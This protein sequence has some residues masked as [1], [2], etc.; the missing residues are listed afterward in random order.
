MTPYPAL[1][2][3]SVCFL[4]GAGLDA[5]SP[6]ER[7]NIIVVFA[8]DHSQQAIS[9]YGSRIN[10]TPNIDR[11]A[12][13]GVRFAESFVTN[14]ICAPSR[15]VMLTGVHS[16]LN[17]QMSNGSRFN[18]DLPTFA[19]LLQGSGYE[20]AMIGKWHLGSPPTGF[21]YWRHAKGRF[22]AT[23][24]HG[25]DGV[26]ENTGH[27]TDI[28]MGDALKWLA[29][30]RDET[31]PFFMWV[32]HMAAHRAWEPATRFLPMYEDVEI[33]EPTTLFDNYE[34]R[35][36]ATEKTQMRIARD[37]F[38]AYDL[39]LP[40]TGKGILDNAAT[41]M[42]NNMTKEERAAWE[43]AYGPRNAAFA[44][45][46][47]EGD[48]LVRWKYQRYIKDYLRC[49]AGLDDALG[50]LLDQLA[51]S[52]LAE[53]T[54]VI[55]TSDQG[56]FLGEH[57]FYDKRW[58]YEPALR[59][60]LIVRWP[61]VTDVANA[62]RVEERMVQNLD[63]APTFIELAGLPVPDS[64]QGTSLVPLLK[65]ESPADWR[66]AIYYHYHQRDSGRTQ[67]TVAPHYGIRT[68]RWKLIYIYDDGKVEPEW[69]LYDLAA[70]PDEMVNLYADPAYST[71]L[72][73]LKEK[74]Q[75]MRR[76]VKDKTGGDAR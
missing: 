1:I 19:K 36:T 76:D 10:S 49:V 46:N 75:A 66:D 47:L 71:T 28:I 40:V 9:A 51:A 44:E 57:G 2:G 12:A 3:L 50:R 43:A 61:G 58:M 24:L 74:L 34:G 6:N 55:Y 48:A 17:G 15:A 72:A 32:S 38:P 42:R 21:D 16:H 62:P 31:K 65:A 45:A 5:Q 22:Y 54:I 70:D 4:I 7:P 56:F 8:D 27:V 29:D 59:T 26:Q 52:G 18:N 25:P 11:L 35:S 64:M 39:K 67:H 14:S 13:S 20:T 41:G 37:L 60:P 23:K 53:N 69:E 33:P 73:M 68:D 63:L 30:G